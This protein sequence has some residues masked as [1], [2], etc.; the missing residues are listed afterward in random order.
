MPQRR[1]E[2]GEGFAPPGKGMSV[3]WTLLL[4]SHVLRAGH[5][6]R[7]RTELRVASPLARLQLAPPDTQM[8]S[9][10]HAQ[11]AGPARVPPVPSLVLAL[12]RAERGQPCPWADFR[13]QG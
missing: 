12:R 2:G 10:A 4:P 11:R 9:H 13:E 8:L 6:P 1:L 7:G 3:A 5:P